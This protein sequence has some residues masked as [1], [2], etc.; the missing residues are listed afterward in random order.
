MKLDAIKKYF[1]SYGLDPD[2]QQ[3]VRQAVW[4]ENLRST[5]FFTLTGAVGLVLC[6]LSPLLYE[7]NPAKAVGFLAFAAACFIVY[8]IVR[9]VFQKPSCTARQ[10]NAVLWLALVV[11]FAGQLYIGCI[12]APTRTSTIYH[13]ILLYTMA[14]FVFEPKAALWGP[15]CSTVCFL[16]VEIFVKDPSLV[17]ADAINA[18]FSTGMGIIVG[19]Y[20]SK[21]RMKG[22]ASLCREA[23]QTEELRI[24]V[25]SANA[26]NMAKSSFMSQMSHEIRTPLNAIIGYNTLA[27]NAITEAKTDE[28]RRQADMSAMDCLTK[29][30]LASKHLL[31]VINDVLDMSAI[32]SGKIKL[33]ND[34]FDF[35]NL[36]SSLTVLFYSQAKAKGIHFDVLFDSPTE[37]WFVGDQ[38]RINQ[39]LTNLLSNAVKF[40]PE[41]GSVTLSILPEAVNDSLMRFYFEISDTGIGM[42]S[43]YIER[44]WQ[45]FEQA[46]SS[47]SRRFGATGL[48]LA[49]TTSLVDIMGGSITVTSELGA[50]SVFKVELT[51][52]RVAQPQETGLYDFS[53]VHALIVDDDKS[54]CDYIQLLFNRCGARSETVNSGK[55][56]IAAFVESLERNDLFTLCLVDWRMRGM[57]G[58]TTVREIRK[59]AGNDVPIIIITAYDYA[60]I[61]ESVKDAGVTM[62]VAKPL[63]QSSLFDLLATVCGASNSQSVAINDVVN[64]DGARA[65]LAEDNEMNMEVAKRILE[66]TGLAVDTARNGREAVSMFENAP[67]GTYQAILMD[68]HMPEMDG[69]QATKAIRGSMQAEGATIP[70]IAMTADAFAENVAEAY[71]AGMNDHIAKPIEV[72]LLF[73]TL[74]KYICPNSGTC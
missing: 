30:E 13:A 37:E 45:P 9:S 14:L 48:G 24:A 15:L 62:F 18:V 41:G 25:E 51:V 33:T 53:D 69:Y 35:K 26:A 72:D 22:F 47:I 20:S 38:M 70:I 21:V 50:G 16:T 58:I 17:L 12:S 1:V 11:M 46:D 10:A 34:R 65:L 64:F 39:V 61:A 44:L 28:E 43:A 68:V 31:T 36:I 7:K 19:M 4:R 29:S 57:D 8:F 52:E 73:K 60:E 63:F 54:T 6:A 2:I 66:A 23:R 42:S 27:K 3:D 40:T 67:A 74:Q 49:I 32:E 71:A 56:A 59:L 5:K 55:E